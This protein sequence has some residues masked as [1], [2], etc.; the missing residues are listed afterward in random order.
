MLGSVLLPSQ[1]VGLRRNTY[2]GGNAPPLPP[3]RNSLSSAPAAQTAKLQLRLKTIP[4]PAKDNINVSTSTST[5]ES[6]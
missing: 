1:P 4:I 2:T 5:M 3:R 6:R